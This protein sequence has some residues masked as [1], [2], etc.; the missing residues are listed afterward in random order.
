MN[1]KKEVPKLRLMFITSTQF[2]AKSITKTVKKSASRTI[3][4][5]TLLLRGLPCMA[6]VC[7]EALSFLEI[8]FNY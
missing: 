6:L 5:K 8:Y 7:M 4:L 2:Y 3:L 1:G